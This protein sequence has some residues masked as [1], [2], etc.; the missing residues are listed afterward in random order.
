M[1]L[2]VKKIGREYCV[3]EDASDEVLA[4]CKTQA[5]AKQRLTELQ[6]QSSEP[7]A[8]KMLD[9]GTKVNIRF[10]GRD[11]MPKKETK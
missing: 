9:N 8:V 5:E 1:T 11:K 4:K 3:V 6:A 7:D 10:V 2:I